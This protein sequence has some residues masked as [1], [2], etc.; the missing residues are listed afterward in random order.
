MIHNHNSN[1]KKENIAAKLDPN[2]MGLQ[3]ENECIGKPKNSTVL[4]VSVLRTH[5][6]Q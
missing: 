4:H 1:D 3:V 5:M 2:L 6:A